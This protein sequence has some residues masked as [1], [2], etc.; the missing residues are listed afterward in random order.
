MVSN[1]TKE[2]RRVA[3]IQALREGGEC[4]STRA[5]LD[6][7]SRNAFERLCAAYRN[8][9]RSGKRICL[10]TGAGVSY[11]KVDRYQTEGWAGILEAVHGELVR[12][13][14]LR[15]DEANFSAMRTRYAKDWDLAQRFLEA[16]GDEVLKNVIRSSIQSWVGLDLGRPS[17]PYKRLPKKYL[18]HQHTLNAAIAFCSR[19]KRINIWPCYEPNLE[20][21]AAVIT[22]NYDWYLEGGATKKYET[23][24]GKALKPISGNDS[25]APESSMPVYH[26]HGYFP[27]DLDTPPRHDLILARTHYEVAYHDEDSFLRTTLDEY[28]P[29]NVLVF[30]G[31]SFQDDFL[32]ERLRAETVVVGEAIHY[33][34][35]K[36]SEVAPG[37]LHEIAAAGVSPIL[38]EDHDSIPWLLGEV[39]K[40]GL[41]E[42]LLTVL[43]PIVS[44][45]ARG[46][47]GANEYWHLL[48][49]NKR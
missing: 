7:E 39:Y 14:C 32:L 9:G 31:I 44:T 12:R 27:Y 28:L 47:A 19:L 26:I 33:A 23:D 42:Q 3:L 40:G 20:K 30:L 29:R 24:V 11:I 1:N 35:L 41:D 2:R 17:R 22:L 34:F 46:S 18:D 37:K 21:V 36:R 16:S 6:G 10:F 15:P 13:D 43:H 4:A 38:Y 8:A 49:Y 25:S 5:E 48:L 45:R